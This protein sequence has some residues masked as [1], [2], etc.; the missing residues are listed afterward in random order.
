MTYTI[1]RPKRTDIKFDRPT[2]ELIPRLT[3]LSQLD[4]E[5]FQ[6][7]DGNIT[8]E[9]NWFAQ[10][11]LGNGKNYLCSSLRW[12]RVG[13]YITSH[14]KS[15]STSPLEYTSHSKTESILYNPKKDDDFSEGE[16]A[17]F[18]QGTNV[19]HLTSIMEQYGYC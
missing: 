15:K 4:Q 14:L 6:D 16:I 11:D 17:W 1:I 10:G 5:I 8:T 3:D 12:K 19:D 18:N 13:A 7:R 9:E 2:L